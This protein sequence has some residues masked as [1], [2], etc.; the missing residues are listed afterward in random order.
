MNFVTKAEKGPPVTRVVTK[1]V[2]RQPLVATGQQALSLV[3]HN[4]GR[5]TE[6]PVRIHNQASLRASS[7][8]QLPV[9]VA[10]KS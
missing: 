7:I 5:T 8:G 1:S 4:L 10:V 3:S 2:Q 6:M 9:F